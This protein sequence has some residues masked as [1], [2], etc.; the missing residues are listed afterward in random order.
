MVNKMC[1]NFL[2]ILGSTIDNDYN[3]RGSTSSFN[4]EKEIVHFDND[5]DIILYEL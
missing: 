3:Y 1:S 5:Q 2:P 4:N